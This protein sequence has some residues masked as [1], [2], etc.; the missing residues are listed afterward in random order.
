M[1]K[2]KVQIL[3]KTPEQPRVKVAK[4]KQTLRTARSGEIFVFESNEWRLGN[5]KLP[6]S[7]L[8]E[9]GITAQVTPVLS[10]S[11]RKMMAELVEEVSESYARKVFDQVISLLKFCRDEL[12]IAAFE[13]WRAAL[14]KEGLGANS[15]IVYMAFCRA[16]LNAWAD[17]N[18]PGLEQGLT[19]H[20][21]RIYSGPITSGQAVRELCP[22]RG[23]FTQAEE[24]A[25][26]RWLH[27]SYANGTLSLQ[28]YAI[29]MVELDYGCRPVELAALRVSDV[30]ER[31]NG[32]GYEIRIP[33]AKGQRNYRESFRVLEMSADLYALL[34]EVILQG[35]EKLA[36]AWGQ[37]ISPRTSKQ[38]PLFVGERLLAAGSS[39]AFEHRIVKT[40]KTFDITVSSYLSSSVRKCPVT[41]ERLDGELLPLSLYRFRRTVATRLAEAGATDETIAA[42][43]GHTSTKTVKVYTAHTYEDQEASDVIMA[44]AWLP[45]M[46]GVKERLLEAPVPG[47]AKVYL[48]RDVD[49]G[50]CSQLCG[51]GFLNCYP[52]A[53]FRPFADAD[54]EEALT[55]AE[56]ERQSRIDKG[57]SGSEV[58]SLDLPIAAIKATILACEIHKKGDSAHG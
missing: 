26:I 44:E 55:K 16:G 29:F 51:G 49:L 7:I 19:D 13:T 52:C 11:F 33:T 15:Q 56:S 22:V 25:L 5:L 8:D 12:T 20:A 27:Q 38:L 36:Q 6:W 32:Q 23:P 24:A 4:V 35:Q 1:E 2:Q 37:P 58:D 28:D 17:G 3:K 18:Y 34:N 53:K 42:I 21:N 30:M 47:Q 50:N 41:T 57:M 31:E 46:D 54:H 39:E 14:S 48:N 40:P 9:K 10:T 45:V 43:L